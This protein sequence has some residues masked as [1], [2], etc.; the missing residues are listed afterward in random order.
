[1]GAV[2]TRPFFP[3]PCSVQAFAVSTLTGTYFRC[4]DTRACS[5]H[6]EARRI[7]AKGAYLPD[8]V[9]GLIAHVH[10]DV[11]SARRVKGIAHP[12]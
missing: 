6:D 7:A 11:N 2:T 10:C 9:D 12:G 5:T 1:V 8:L 4:L 3:P